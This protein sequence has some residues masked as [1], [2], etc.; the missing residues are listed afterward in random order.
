M[1]QASREPPRRR[2]RTLVASVSVPTV[3]RRRSPALP[4]PLA[5]TGQ[6]FDE[7][8]RRVDRAAPLRRLPDAAERTGFPGEI[9]RSPAPYDRPVVAWYATGC[10]AGSTLPALPADR[11]GRVA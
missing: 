10:G 2:Q 5:R 8:G 11:R 9:S 6:R 4:P 3:P 1:H 7:C